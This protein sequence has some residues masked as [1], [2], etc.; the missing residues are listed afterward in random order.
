MRFNVSARIWK[1]SNEI[2]IM[3]KKGTTKTQEIDFII[4]EMF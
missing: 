4:E 3:I 1:N 2:H